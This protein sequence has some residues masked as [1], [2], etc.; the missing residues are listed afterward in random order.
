MT[1]PR[2]PALGL[3]AAA[4]GLLGFLALL[5]SGVGPSAGQSPQLV[6]IPVVTSGLS[7]PVDLQHAGDGRMFIVE[8]AGR[9]RVYKDGMLLAPPFLD[10]S[11]QVAG[12]TEQG[13]L[14]LAFSPSYQA[15][16]QFYIYFTDTAGDINIRRYTVPNPTADT[17][18]GATVETVFF[19]NHPPPTNHNG[20]QLAFSG[21]Q[22]W[23]GTGDGGGGG[24]PNPCAARDPGSRLGKMLRMPVES[25]P[26]PYPVEIV[27]RG[28]RNP[29]R[30][31]FAGSSLYI[32]DVG[33]GSWEEVNIVSTSATGLDFGWDIMEGTHCF[34]PMS[35][36]SM[37]GL[38]LPQIEYSHAAGHCSVTGGYVY[39]GTR[40]PSMDG[41]YFYADYCSGTIWGA[42]QPLN[43]SLSITSFGL[44]SSGNL[45]VL[46]AG[47]GVYLLGEAGASPP[48]ET[49][50]AT[51]TFT[52]SNTPTSTPTWTPTATATPTGTLSP[53]PTA[54][55]TATPTSTPT[56]RGP[57]RAWVP[58]AAKP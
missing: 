29:W 8:K 57:N 22:L 4:A 13:L 50:T 45:Y 28:L 40:F 58:Q 43:T 26:G 32:G 16:G 12:D 36:C 25:G 56:P 47:G 14:G 31:S 55:A 49:P 33:Q 6:L 10:I 54:T 44:D 51:P 23:F 53:T 2:R 38:T 48:T 52:P 9:I 30:F 21:G 42:S 35:G 27:H 17:A 46:D 11:G 19:L 1:A 39:S 34:E 37:A 5:L 15:N 7:F 3:L 20:G 18:A 24:C 41:R